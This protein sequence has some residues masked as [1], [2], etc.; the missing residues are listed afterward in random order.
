M[1]PVLL[2]PWRFSENSFVRRHIEKPMT[3]AA[4]SKQLERML[5]DANEKVIALSGA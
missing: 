2:T 3:I 5:E 4:T 1:P